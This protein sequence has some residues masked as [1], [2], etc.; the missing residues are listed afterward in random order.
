MGLFT[1]PGERPATGATGK[2]AGANGGGRQLFIEK[3]SIWVYI[4]FVFQ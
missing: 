3:F 4:C 1:D 2:D